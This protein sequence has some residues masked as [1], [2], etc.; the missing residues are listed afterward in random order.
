ME[1]LIRKIVIGRDPKNGMAYYI[2]MRAGEGKVSA[3][4]ED[5][6]HLSK[7]GKVRYLIY[8]EREDGNLLWKAV[9]EMP[10]LIEFDLNF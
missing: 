10:C 4:L 7:F 8:I 3:I 2:G 9:D 6:R 1:G 5:Q